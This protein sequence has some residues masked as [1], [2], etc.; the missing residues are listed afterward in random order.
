MAIGTAR[1]LALLLAIAVAGCTASRSDRAARALPDDCRAPVMYVALGDSTVAGV[2]ATRPDRNYVSQI[3]ARLRAIYPAARVENL[4]VSGAV[5]A[6]VDK[7]QLDR[8]LSLDPDLVTL[9]V[10]PNDITRGVPVEKYER[11]IDT[12]LKA[13]TRQKQRV[14]VVNLLPDLAITPRFARS[15]K[16]EVVGRLTVRF[17]EALAKKA[18]EYGAEVVDLY[19]RSR[20]EVPRQPEL[21]AADGYHPSD[22]G[23]AR[24]AELMWER[25]APRM[26]HC[27]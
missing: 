3:H 25:I 7:D 4:G 21:V 16:R 11:N 12:I 14:V 13:L 23:Y 10:G 9:S 18:R 26:A 22:L 2:A 1:T 15:D 19:E 24:W 27:E 8:A 20:D 5:S 6:D 17:N